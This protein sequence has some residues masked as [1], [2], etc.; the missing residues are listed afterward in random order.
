MAFATGKD[1]M[2]TTEALVQSLWKHLQAEFVIEESKGGNPLPTFNGEGSKQDTRRR[3][4]D[5]DTSFPRI[6]Y[7]EAMTRYGSDKPDLRIPNQIERIE[8]LVP[9]SFTSMITHIPSPIVEAW[10]FT[11][12]ASPTEIRAFVK[13]FMDALADTTTQTSNTSGE[14]PVFL[15]HDSSK[16]LSGLAPLGHEGAANL[17]SVAN[18]PFPS[19]CDGD[20][21][22]VQARDANVP[23]QGQGSTALGTVRREL[24]YAAIARGLL[25]A[26]NS[27]RF[28]WVTDFPL[29]TP[30]SAT[31]ADPG[32]GG[33]SGFSSTH[34]PFTSPL[35]AQDMDLLLTSPLD[36]RADHYDLVVNGVELGGGSRRIHVEGL[37]RL[38]L[39]HVLGME[40]DRVEANFGHLLTA[41]RAGCP[42]HAGIALGFDRLVA[43]LT[44]T[45]SVRDV[46][47][48]PKSA[49]G[50]DPAV[51]SPGKVS[52]EQWRTYHLEY[53]KG[54]K[55]SGVQ[56][57]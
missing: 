38:V 45:G 23:F 57:A 39:E 37:Q 5:I 4:P 8:T 51:K 25:P 41:L 30:S 55:K 12:D 50:E 35:A 31:P 17:T 48:F 40:R 33:A 16:P 20:V 21:L 29:F 34:H 26:D 56:S 9:E 1:V 44:F 32:Q 53:F 36:A 6:T 15:I 7:Q 42:P 27:F 22:V 18:A 28:L 14:A 54:G 46:I 2:E 3:Y 47:A 52:P 43:L 13:D 24:Y 49:K 19:L 10:R 11:L